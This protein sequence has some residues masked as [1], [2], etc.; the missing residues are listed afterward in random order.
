MKTGE[1]KY[2]IEHEERNIKA[3]EKALEKYCIRKWSSTTHRMRFKN[4]G[5]PKFFYVRKKIGGTVTAIQKIE[6]RP[7]NI[8]FSAIE[9]LLM[10]IGKPVNL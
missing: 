1:L 7:L 4:V 8:V 5:K 2:V 6:E 10:R 3:A 9:K